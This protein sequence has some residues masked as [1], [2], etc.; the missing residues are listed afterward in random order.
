MDVMGR[1][2]KEPAEL[3]TSDD[4]TKVLQGGERKVHSGVY[5]DVG[6]RVPKIRCQK[7]AAG[8]S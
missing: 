5:K 6:D 7:V 2:N 8:N 1:F 3:K 4:E